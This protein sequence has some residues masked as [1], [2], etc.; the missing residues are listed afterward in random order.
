MIT[1]EHIS[2][3]MKNIILYY[4]QFCDP[5][6]IALTVSLLYGNKIYSNVFLYKLKW[7]VMYWGSLPNLKYLLIFHRRLAFTV[8]FDDMIA[9]FIDL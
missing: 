5:G 8:K 1:V 3:K 7:H 4:G 6:H 2:T 9:L